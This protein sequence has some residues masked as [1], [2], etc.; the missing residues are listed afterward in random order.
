MADRDI[1]VRIRSEVE[2]DG[3]VNALIK[4]IER[5]AAEG[6]E[7]APKF[8]ALAEEIRG[9]AS[10]QALIDRFAALKRETLAAGQAADQAQD[11]VR[12]L[13]QAMKAADAPTRQLE[14]DFEK[15]K[16]AARASRTELELKSRALQSLRS[17][18]AQAG[19]S[20]TQLAQADSRLRV[21]VQSVEERVGLLQVAYAEAGQAAERGAQRQQAANKQVTQSVDAL[22]NKLQGLVT[23]ISAVAGVSLGANLIHDAAATADAYEN[24]AARIRLV[25]GEGDAFESAFAGV[26]QVALETNSTLEATGELFGRIAAAGKQFGIGTDAA[27]A[28]VRTI[29]QAVQLSGASAEASDAAVRQLVQG[30]QSGVLRGDEFNSV[31]EQSPRLAQAL[32]AGLNVTTGELREMAAQG[33]LT[34]QVVL[35]ALQSQSSAVQSE[36]EHLPATIGRAVT[37]LSTQWEVFIGKANEAGGV[38][39]QVAGAITLLANNLDTVAG[40]LLSMGKAWLAFRAFNIAAEFLGVKKAVDAT[41]AAKL[42]EAAA[43][44]VA[45]RATVANT[46]ALGANTAAHAA[47]ATA[48][49]GVVAGVSNVTGM[50]GKLAGALSLLRTFSWAFLLTNLPEIGKWIGE[51]AAKM[52]GYGKAIEETERQLRAQERAAQDDAAQNAE[53]AAKQKRAQEEALG[54]SKAAKALVADFE[55]QRKKGESTADAMDKLTKAMQLGNIDGIRDAGAALDALQQKGVVTADQVRAAWA[56]ALDGKDLQVFEANARAAFD[57]TEQG[58]R[59]LQAALDGALDESIRRTGVSLGELTRGI[60]DGAQQAIDNFDYLAQNVDR[61]KE[62]GIDTGRALQASLEKATATA[63]TSAALDAV[64][65]RWEELGRQGLITGEQLEKGLE[66]ARAKL[67]ALLPGINSVDEAF[68]TLGLKSRA[69]LQK[70]AKSYQ[71]AFNVIRNSGSTLQEQRAAFQKYA[72]AAIAA[73][74][75]VASSTLQTQAAMLGLQVTTDSTGKSIVSAMGEGSQSTDKLTGSL[76]NAK[77]AS[78][79]LNKSISDRPSEEFNPDWRNPL[80]ESHNDELDASLTQQERDAGLVKRDVS[81]STIDYRQLGLQSG[82]RGDALDRFV[83]RFQSELE[84]SLADFN[85]NMRGQGA[86]L[87]G[88]VEANT[89][90]REFGGAVDLARA[91][92]LAYAQQKPKSEDKD[93]GAAAAPAAATQRSTFGLSPTRVVQIDLNVNGQTSSVYAEEGAEQDLIAALQAAKGRS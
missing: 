22:G 41:A 90:A 66:G 57:G 10:Q 14:S 18:L 63:D 5:L 54:L 15:A 67:D 70:T 2:G 42:Q 91:R 87:G 26:Q 27:L 24:L 32:A 59:R 3:E 43:T 17:E 78:D 30:L 7:A 60:S 79:R 19:I 36:F 89:Y 49:K 80:S 8:R 86:A 16:A 44:G 84:S 39:H 93:S 51:T 68:R 25:T 1:T 50:V 72:E 73:N 62:K 9:I 33:A 75:G 13:A 77:V 6:G 92:A 55:E 52:M 35:S 20:T 56:K 69:D 11:K 71:D 45:T 81:T 88:T 29:N 21:E 12:D 4:E 34:S 31:M 38:T 85:K 28:L 37:N 64:I 74:G 83:G 46:A 47:N 53:L 61:L 76:N 82:L 58:A 48:S 65:K 40:A 23:T